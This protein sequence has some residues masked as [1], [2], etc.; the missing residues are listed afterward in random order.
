VNKAC[1]ITQSTK[2]TSSWVLYIWLPH[3]TLSPPPLHF[4]LLHQYTLLPRIAWIKCVP[5]YTVDLLSFLYIILS[6]WK[7]KWDTKVRV[8]ETK[9]FILYILFCLPC[10]YAYV[11]TYLFSRMNGETVKCWWWHEIKTGR[12]FSSLVV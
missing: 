4:F 10:R 12:G 1:L 5:I 9:L 7:R 11:R 2:K 6:K 3:S 8:R